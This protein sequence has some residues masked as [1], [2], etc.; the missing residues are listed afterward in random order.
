LRKGGFYGSLNF[1]SGLVEVANRAPNH[2]SCGQ[3]WE[4]GH[5]VVPVPFTV[6]CADDAKISM[7]IQPNDYVGDRFRTSKGADGN[8]LVIVAVTRRLGAQPEGFGILAAV[9]GG[10]F[11]SIGR[12]KA[13]FPAALSEFAL[14]RVF[15]HANCVWRYFRRELY[16]NRSSSGARSLRLPLDFTSADLV[17]I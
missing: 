14:L 10:K 13:A 9:L 2:L 6:G 12:I 11:K 4:E 17:D 16:S 8:F 1:F 7:S 15:A 5:R 3:L